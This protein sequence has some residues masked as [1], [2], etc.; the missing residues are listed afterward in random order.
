MNKE[1]LRQFLALRMTVSLSINDRCTLH[2]MYEPCGDPNPIKDE[3]WLDIHGYGYQ[4][5][6]PIHSRDCDEVCGFVENVMTTFWREYSKA[7]VGKDTMYSRIKNMTMEEMQHFVYWVYLCGNKD[8]ED[9]VCDSALGFF[10]GYMLT[11]ERAE[12][13]PNDSIDDLWDRFEQIYRK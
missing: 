11:K 1:S 6:I 4:D 13:M 3:L 8:G 7:C 12:L 5:S 2:R 10:G 9:G